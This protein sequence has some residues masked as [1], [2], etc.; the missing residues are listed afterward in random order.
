MYVSNLYAGSISD[1]ELTHCSGILDLLEQGDS[2]MADCG[3]DIQDHL[4][5]QGVRLNIPPFLKGKSQLNESDLV[6]TRRIASIRIHVE[7]AMERIKIFYIF[8]KTLPSS[9]SSIAN[10]TFC[11][12][13]VLS[14]FHPPLCT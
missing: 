12:Y 13:A 1:K 11:V 5:L 2:V 14:N 8:D 6:E 10:Q 3:F 7:Q 4:T 9:M